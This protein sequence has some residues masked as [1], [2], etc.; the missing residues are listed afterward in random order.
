MIILK[1]ILD[2]VFENNLKISEEIDD[3]AAKISY[4]FQYDKNGNEVMKSDLTTNFD[5][6]YVYGKTGAIIKSK[7]TEYDDYEFDIVNYFEFIKN[8]QLVIIDSLNDVAIAAI[9]RM[10]TL[11]SIGIRFEDQVSP[12]WLCTNAPHKVFETFC[13]VRYEN[14]I[15]HDQS[16]FR[17]YL[18]NFNYDDDDDEFNILDDVM[19]ECEDDDYF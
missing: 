8:C 11:W 7:K 5:S 3:P 2:A 4:T 17:K 18:E 10:L 6:H 1:K 14:G 16:S 13:E 12:K 15:V 19:E 9:K